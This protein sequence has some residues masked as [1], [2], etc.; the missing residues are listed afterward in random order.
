VSP[1]ERYNRYFGGGRDA[2][3]KTL[4]AMKKT[5][6]PKKGEHVFYAAIAKRE[7]KAKTRGGRR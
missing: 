1:L 6:G 5:Y 4:A 2:A 3:Q 7:R